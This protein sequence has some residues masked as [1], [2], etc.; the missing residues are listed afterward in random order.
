MPLTDTY[1]QPTHKNHRK[2]DTFEQDL[3]IASKKN[4]KTQN[5][6]NLRPIRTRTIFFEMQHEKTIFHQSRNLLNLDFRTK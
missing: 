6:Q 5:Y 2:Q 4:N 1:W 3:A